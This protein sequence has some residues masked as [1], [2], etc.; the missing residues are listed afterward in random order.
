MKTLLQQRMELEKIEPAAYKAMLELQ[1]Y[2][3]SSGINK[4]LLEL[5]KIRASQINSC[6]FCIDMHTKDARKHG[7]TEQ[8]IYALNAWR[9]TPFFTLEERAVLA[10]TEAVTLIS[11][12]HVSDDVYQEVSRYFAPK[13]IAQIVMTII[14][15]NGWNRI[16]VTTRMV[17][18]TDE[19]HLRQLREKG[20]V[21]DTL[22]VK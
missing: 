20:L 4:N 14:T 18:G 8:R 5:I 17:P 9:E 16:A 10:L 19:E 12:N 11:K 22:S 1:K 3:D 21:P 6:A 2:V 13:E 7:E 15:I